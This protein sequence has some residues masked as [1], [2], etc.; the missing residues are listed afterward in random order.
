ML[1]RQGDFSPL[2]PYIRKEFFKRDTKKI[3]IKMLTEIISFKRAFKEHLRSILRLCL[4]R[5][6]KCIQLRM[7]T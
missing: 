1:P 5:L 2:Y 7:E 3:E 4:K 6:R